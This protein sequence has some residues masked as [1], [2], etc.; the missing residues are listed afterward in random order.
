MSEHTKSNEDAV[1]SGFSEAVYAVLRSSVSH[2][3]NSDQYI[4]LGD[5]DFSFG[6]NLVVRN[7]ELTPTIQ[8][9]GF[10]PS[11]G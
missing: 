1:M 4:R 8:A 6:T 2:Q 5:V 10:M 3:N 11:D 7:L 9:L